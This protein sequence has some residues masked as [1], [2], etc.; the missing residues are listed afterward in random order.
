MRP[1][2][3]GHP[4]RISQRQGTLGGTDSVIAEATAVTT[5]VAAITTVSKV[6][7]Q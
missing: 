4:M 7:N 3:R 1:R 2:H 5:A 6:M